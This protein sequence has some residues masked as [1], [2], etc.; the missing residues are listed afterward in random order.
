MWTADSLEKI[1]MLRKMEAKRRRRQQRMRWLDAI[2]DSMDMSLSSL[3]EI[4]K[5]REAWC[6]AVHGGHKELDMTGWLNNNKL[7]SLSCSC[8]QL[9]RQQVLPSQ[10]RDGQKHQH[11][12]PWSQRHFNA[13]VWL[14]L[15]H[16]C[17]LSLQSC[18][19]LCDPRDCVPSGSYVHRILQARILEWV[20]MPSSR[21]SSPGSHTYSQTYW[22]G[23]H[24]RHF[25]GA[26]K[27][28]RLKVD[29][30]PQTKATIWGGKRRSPSK[31]QSP[32]QKEKDMDKELHCINV[33]CP[34][35]KM[36]GYFISA[37]APQ[38]PVGKKTIAMKSLPGFLCS[39]K[40]IT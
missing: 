14:L 38:L 36:W 24:E 26:Q 2:A 25:P 33:R 16:M 6:A 29:L 34:K 37:L 15:V 27:T 4:V 32:L 13:P 12:L 3:W 21:G 17:M 28:H 35:S 30:V 8:Y 1:L 39:L 18:L 5:D 11:L 19:T 10:W 40:E 20:A 31:N 22:C 7:W 9:L 23:P